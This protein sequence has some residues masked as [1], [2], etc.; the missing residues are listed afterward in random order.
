MQMSLFPP[1]ICTYNEFLI[2]RYFPIS[3]F[4]NYALMFYLPLMIRALL[5]LCIT[6][7]LFRA[8]RKVF[9]VQIMDAVFRNEL[10]PV[11]PL[12]IRAVSFGGE[13][14]G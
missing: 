1:L 3:L 10:V 7:L 4:I 12:A 5:Y 11:D 6:T 2:S 13:T 14:A 9:H 8:A